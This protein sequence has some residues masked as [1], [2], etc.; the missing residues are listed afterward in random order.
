MR[1][2][3]DVQ[4]PC[5]QMG[6]TIA[7]L[8]CP[9]TSVQPSQRVR[10]DIKRV[11]CDLVGSRGQSGDVSDT[12]G[13]PVGL[14]CEDESGLRSQLIGVKDGPSFVIRITPGVR[15]HVE[16][17]AL[18]WMEVQESPLLAPVRAEERL[19]KVSALDYTFPEGTSVRTWVQR[20]VPADQYQNA[21]VSLASAL[22]LCVDSHERLSILLDPDLAFADAAGY[23]RFCCLP[24]QGR[25]VRRHASLSAL[26]GVLSAPDVKV[27]GMGARVR[28]QL[29]SLMAEY[30]GAVDL[31]LLVF[32]LSNMAG[33]PLDA[34]L[35]SVL[36]EDDTA[37]TAEG[38]VREV[39]AASQEPGV[40]WRGVHDR[41]FIEN[42]RRDSGSAASAQAGRPTM[43]RSLPS[44]V[45]L[46]PPAEPQ[47]VYR[48]VIETPATQVPKGP[49][50]T[51]PDLS[52]EAGPAP[53]RESATGA[54]EG[55]STPSARQA[56]TY[57]LVRLSTGEEFVLGEGEEVRLGRGSACTVR[58]HQN[59]RIS[60]MHATLRCEGERVLLTDEGSANGVWVAGA[61]LDAH[62]TREVALGERFSLA[63]EE[64]YVQRKRG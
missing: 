50:V 13:K 49:R 14:A 57:V 36:E 48:P 33:Y 32:F 55:P 10:N 25:S 38:Q 17:D 21:L 27:L 12:I 18:S 62:E 23:L 51:Q 47:T 30:E 42:Y 37:G 45:G 40:S 59:P 4:A 20:P 34:D 5:Q 9:C 2:Y 53:A 64:F 56:R 46:T 28:E 24:L 58:I 11:S 52:S 26:L 43:P 39:P 8:L 15:E 19:G 35:L 41:G 61:R 60:R 31:A 3:T 16:Y 1:T 29:A 6:E 7:R 44:V 22:R 54:P 63:N